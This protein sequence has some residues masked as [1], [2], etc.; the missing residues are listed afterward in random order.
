MSAVDEQRAERAVDDRRGGLLDTAPGPRPITVPALG[1]VTDDCEHDV[2]GTCPATA[3]S[4][5]CACHLRTPVRLG[6]HPYPGRIP[7]Q[8]TA[9][10]VA[11]GR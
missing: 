10:P 1:A 3:H 7:A 4:C 5:A 9:E 11:V 6:G 8:R 2:H